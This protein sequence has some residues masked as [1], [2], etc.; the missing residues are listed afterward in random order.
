MDYV[1][2]WN[3]CPDDMSELI[4]VFITVYTLIILLVRVFFVRILYY[5]AKE[6]ELRNPAYQSLDGH[7]RDK[8]NSNNI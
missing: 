3:D 7:I 4:W 8:D 1:M 6:A 2:D 5:Y